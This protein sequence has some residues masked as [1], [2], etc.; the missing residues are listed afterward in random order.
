MPCPAAGTADVIPPVKGQPPPLSLAE[1]AFAFA[2]RAN[3]RRGQTQRAQ[4]TLRFFCA[5][6]LWRVILLKRLPVA[7]RWLFSLVCRQKSLT[8]MFF[9]SYQKSLPF[10]SEICEV[11]HLAFCA[12]SA[13][14]VDFFASAPYNEAKLCPPGFGKNKSAQLLSKVAVFCK[15]AA[16]NRLILH[17]VCQEFSFALQF[18]PAGGVDR[19]G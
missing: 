10:S 17:F 5:G 13:Q 6:L 8:C 7:C 9:L 18:A 1:R 15:K 4:R 12:F 19:M 3:I 2:W 11:N 16:S 14:R